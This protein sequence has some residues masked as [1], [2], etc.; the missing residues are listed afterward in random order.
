[1]WHLSTNLYILLTLSSVLTPT[2]QKWLQRET[3]EHRGD[4]WFFGCRI[5]TWGSSALT[6]YRHPLVWLSLHNLF[7]TSIVHGFLLCF[8]VYFFTLQKHSQSLSRTGANHQLELHSWD[9]LGLFREVNASWHK[10]TAPLPMG[11]ANFSSI[12]TGCTLKVLKTLLICAKIKAGN[13][14]KQASKN[15]SFWSLVTSL[16]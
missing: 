13:A 2:L 3:I 15:L 14:G 1:M 16:Y 7:L 6:Y 9:S 11:S 10:D 4:T 5:Y 12:I 8:Q